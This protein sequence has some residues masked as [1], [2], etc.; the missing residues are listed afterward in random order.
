MGKAIKKSNT[1]PC[2]F[3][4]EDVIHNPEREGVGN[5][6]GDGGTLGQVIMKA[7]YGPRKIA[8]EHPLSMPDE[9]D[10]YS[11]AQAHHLICSESVNNDDW[12]EICATFGYDI[13]CVENGIFLPADL[14]VACQLKVPLHRGNH[15]ATETE[16]TPDYVN[17]VKQKILPVRDAAIDGEYCDKP[18]S[19][20]GKMNSISKEIWANV[21]AFDWI[22]TYD[23]MD[24]KGGVKG[25][26]GAKG[27]VSKR[28]SKERRCPVGRKHSLS[29]SKSQV[30]KEQ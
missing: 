10:F 5:N 21:K 16:E 20:I 12:A 9:T 7:K 29:I 30:F 3:C 14:R 24:Y 11:I 4:D 17:A 28:A 18:K 19:I 26:L 22:L 23:G 13:N 6:I 8:S 1:E 25:C 27:L 15:S 2:N